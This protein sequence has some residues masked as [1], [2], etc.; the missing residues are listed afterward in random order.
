MAGS[1]KTA[2]PDDRFEREAVSAGRSRVVGVDEVG[3]GPLAGP[4]TAAA[5]WLDPA[6]MPEGLDDSK[7]LGPA[8]RAR[9][10]AQLAETADIAVGHASVEEIDRLNILRAAHLAMV[11][12]VAGLSVA[13]DFCL[14]DGTMVPAGLACEAQAL[15]RG[16]ARSLSIAAASIVAKTARDAL[17]ADLAVRHPGYGWEQNAGYPTPAHKAALAA[18]GPSPAHRRSFRPV[19]AVLYGSRA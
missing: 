19:R 6:R 14:V 13:P 4:V 11:R 5:V 10:A 3:R 16:D 1:G 9:L 2:S 8:R 12:A 7:R 17:M 15:V 18:L